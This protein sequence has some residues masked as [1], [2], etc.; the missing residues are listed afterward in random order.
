MAEI[1]KV[2][3]TNKLTVAAPLVFHLKKAK[4]SQSVRSFVIDEKIA[5]KSKEKHRLHLV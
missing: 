4:I 2:H 1:L 5:K 3:I